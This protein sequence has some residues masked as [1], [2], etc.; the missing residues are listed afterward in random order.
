MREETPEPTRVPC[1]REPPGA[2]E[3]SASMRG[4]ADSRQLHPTPGSPNDCSDVDLH[5][6]RALNNRG[7]GGRR[8]LEEP[9]GVSSPSAT[10]LLSHPSPAIG[11]STHD[12]L[13]DWQRNA[14]ARRHLSQRACRAGGSRRGRVKSPLRCEDTPTRVNFTRPPA[15]QT[16]WNLIFI[17]IEH[18]ITEAMGVGGCLRSPWAYP[19]PRRRNFCRTHRPGGL[20]GCG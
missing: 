19:R 16:C 7:D 10:K 14:T 5:P 3:V 6:Y 2:G 20:A 4:Y 1:G 13:G 15:P 17:R 12:A 18:S 8:M 11:H 9:L